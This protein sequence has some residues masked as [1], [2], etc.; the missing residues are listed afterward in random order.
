MLYQTPNPH[1]GDVYG[2]SVALDFSANTNPCGTPEGVLRAIREALPRLRQ[3]PDPY[4]RDLVRAIGDF[5]GVPEQYILCGNGAAELIYAY[6]EAARPGLA[7]ETAPTFSEYALG[8]ARAGGT[9]LR[10]PL[11]REQ[12]F[13]L[14]RRFLDFLQ[15][16]KPEAVF[17]CNPNNPTG[18]VIAP[19]LLEEILD[20]TRQRGMRLFVDECFL[21][22]SERGE[23]LKQHL[24]DNPQLLI[25]KAFTKSYGMAGARLGYCLSADGA[26]LGRMAAAVQ[27]WNVSSLAQAAG[28]A[29]LKEQAFLQRARDIIFTEKTWLAARLEELG[30]WVCPSA[31]NYLLFQGPEGLHTALREKRIAIRDCGNYHGLGPG[32]YRVAVRLHEEN[33]ALISAMREIMQG[34]QD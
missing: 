31:A 19:G 23:S 22:L 6:C 8:L 25:L 12:A 33:E 7:A 3:Y 18:Q 24:E 16:E 30:L 4:C 26:L 20:H 15:Q 11:D 13:T 34:G 32:W 1:G 10:H 14:D 27:P 29:A 21:D 9:M 5:E 2:E 17:L 28:V